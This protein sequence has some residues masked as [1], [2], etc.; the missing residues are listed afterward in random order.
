MDR[1]HQARALS[2]HSGKLFCMHRKR[3][4][5]NNY[6]GRLLSP[7]EWRTSPSFF[8]YFIAFLSFILCINVGVVSRQLAKVK[9]WQCAVRFVIC[10]FI[11][12]AK[13]RHPCRPG[14]PCKCASLD[15]PAATW[16][17]AVRKHDACIW[18]TWT[19]N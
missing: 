18:T 6:L 7:H 13:K 11:V 8:F 1:I 15:E 4:K 16:P 17:A 14:R 5:S 3:A 9:T 2:F 12:F 10:N 19:T